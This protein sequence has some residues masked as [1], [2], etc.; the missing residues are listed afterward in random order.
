MHFLTCILYS[1]MFSWA[2]MKVDEKLTVDFQNHM[3]FTVLADHLQLWN[4]KSINMN[5][6]MHM[7]SNLG[8]TVIPVW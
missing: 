8:M 1:T 5:L 4:E 2:P 3:K 6:W 7:C